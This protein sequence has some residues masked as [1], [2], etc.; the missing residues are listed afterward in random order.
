MT[1]KQ[2]IYPGT[3]LKYRVTF[4]D[5][6]FDPIE[7]DWAV[8]LLNA[9]GQK[10]GEATKEQALIDTEGRFYITLRAMSGKYF[11]RTSY[12]MPDKDFETGHGQQTDIQVLY[13]TGCGCL[14]RLK[15]PCCETDTEHAVTFERV[16]I[17]NVEGLLILL[18][19]NGDAIIGSDGNTILVHKFKQA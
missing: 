13:D 18:D 4:N 8:E 1:G 17:Q 9:Y 14:P 19:R 5:E 2:R 15:Q 10:V 12:Q 3:D 6:G 7:N 11:A 16:N